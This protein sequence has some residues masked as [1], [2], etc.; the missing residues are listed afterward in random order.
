MWTLV[1]SL[2]ADAGTDVLIASVRASNSSVVIEFIDVSGR[3]I[4]SLQGLPLPLNRTT[5][6]ALVDAVRRLYELGYQ[7]DRDSIRG[8]ERRLQGSFK[9][10]PHPTLTRGPVRRSRTG[11]EWSSGERIPDDS[12][13][14]RGG[15]VRRSARVQ[16]A[17]PAPGIA[18]V[19]RIA[20]RGR[21]RPASPDDLSIELQELF[22]SSAVLV[23]G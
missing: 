13:L 18:P 3:P 20:V 15:P 16:H 6:G 7:A 12:G 14:G 2:P 21:T 17:R 23:E 5:G 10:A 9:S 8:A 1:D 4:A 19:A 22:R 11:H